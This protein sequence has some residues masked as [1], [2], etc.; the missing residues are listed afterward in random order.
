[1]RRRYGRDRHYNDYRES[2]YNES[3]SV[4]E[5]IFNDKDLKRKL[6]TLMDD[7]ADD[8]RKLDLETS[9]RAVRTIDNLYYNVYNMLEDEYGEDKI[10]NQVM[11][12]ALMD[13][14]KFKNVVFNSK[15]DDVSRTIENPLIIIKKM[16]GGLKGLYSSLNPI[17]VMERLFR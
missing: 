6:R 7:Y 3:E 10:T 17:N 4:S 8:V 14:P 15:R 11:A 16:K 5:D 12:D 1:M 9:Q 13:I 2:F